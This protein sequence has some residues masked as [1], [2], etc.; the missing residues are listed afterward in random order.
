MSKQ[1]SITRFEPHGPADS[2]L[3]RWNYVSADSFTTSEQSERGHVYFTD[4]TGTLTSGVWDCTAFTDPQG[5]YPVNEFMLVLEGSVT[6]VDA[7]GHEETIRAGESFVIPKGLQCSW[8]QSE[9]IRKFFV[10]FDDPSGVEAEDPTTLKVL[11]PNPIAELPLMEQQDT[12]RYVGEIPTH[13]LLSTF[14]DPGGQM[15]VG[16][17]DTTDMHTNLFDFNRSELMH[18][19]E[20]EVLLTEDDGQQ[21]HFR[22]GDTFMVAKGARFKWD[23]DGYVRKIYCIFEP[24]EA[25]A[26]AASG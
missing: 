11:R 9:Y 17:W 4:A 15:H 14:D 5:P 22:A 23:S 7:S 8:K 26:Q 24:R 21:H 3:S 20:G 1:Q 25:L 19:L 18:L 2:G 6:I 10:I 13:H 12:S 16:V